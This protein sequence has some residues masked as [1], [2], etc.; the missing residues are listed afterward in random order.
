LE[1]QVK[2]CA[3]LFYVS[4]YRFVDMEQSEAIRTSILSSI[5]REMFD[6][7]TPDSYQPKLSNTPSLVR[8]ACEIA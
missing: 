7:D 5:W 1:A 8:E 3:S 4:S 6:A 2:T